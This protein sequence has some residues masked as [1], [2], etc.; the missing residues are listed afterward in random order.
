MSFR[1][2]VAN[3]HHKRGIVSCGSYMDA[4]REFE[5]RRSIDGG[6][7]Y[8]QVHFPLLGWMPIKVK[9]GEI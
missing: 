5:Q 7:T 1:V 8:L 3:I 9:G 2:Y 4:L 6:D